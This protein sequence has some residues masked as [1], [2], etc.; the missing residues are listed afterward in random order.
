MRFEKDRFFLRPRTEDVEVVLYIHG[1]GGNAEEAEHYRQFFPR[2]DIYGFDYKSQ[3]PWEAK[4]EFCDKV[5]ELSEKYDRI[6]LIA[7]SIGAYFSMNADIGKFIDK[8]Y[9]ISPI[10]NLEKLILD[11]INWAGTSESELE[12]RK[13]IPTDFGDDLSWDYLQYVRN[14]KISWNVP[15]EILYGSNDNLQSIDTIKEFAMKES[16]GLTVMEGGEHWFHTDEQ[17]RFLNQWL[18]T[19]ASE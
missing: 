5:D 17:M 11:M 4:K 15:T 14:N 12:K 18:R 10:V 7:V 3:N 9:F 19:K 8:A 6:T 1:K 16:A 13:I 2:K